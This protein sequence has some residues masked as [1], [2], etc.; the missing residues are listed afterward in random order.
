MTYRYYITLVCCIISISC[1][2]HA[3][4]NKNRLIIIRNQCPFIINIFHLSK[5]KKI[6]ASTETTIESHIFKK[7][8]SYIQ[9][10]I[11]GTTKF[12]SVTIIHNQDEITLQNKNHKIEISNLVGLITTLTKNEK[13]KDTDSL[14]DETYAAKT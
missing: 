3:M 2:A 4:N 5:S 11:P 10:L 13:H 9:F 14:S 6:P 1:L 8:K 7:N 12:A